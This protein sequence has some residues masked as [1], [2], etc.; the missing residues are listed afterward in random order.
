MPRVAQAAFRKACEEGAF[1]DQLIAY[2]SEFYEYY[3]QTPQLA[4][5][6]LREVTFKQGIV[7]QRMLATMKGIEKNL[8]RLV[9]KAQADGV[10]NSALAPDEV[11]H[12]IFSLHRVEIRFCLDAEQ[13]SATASLAH[14]RNQ[15]EILF[16]GLAVR[17]G[18]KIETLTQPMSRP[19]SNR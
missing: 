14:L 7:A 16:D 1:L 2:F 9:A 11:S 15:F 13:P 10:I 8:A 5:D 12:L 19:R 3:I 4:R 18:G 17:G 6:M